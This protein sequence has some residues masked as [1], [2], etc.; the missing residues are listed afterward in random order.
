M[1]PNYTGWVVVQPYSTNPSYHWTSPP[2]GTNYQVFVGVRNAGSVALYQDSRYLGPF[3]IVPEAPLVVTGLTAN[4]T[5]P[6]PA[7][8]PIT[9]TATTTGGTAPL[10]Y[11]FWRNTNFTGWVIVQPY[12]TSNTYLWASPTAGSHQI[13]VGVRNAGSTAIYDQSLG[14]GSF[15]VTTAVLTVTSLTADVTLPSPAGV[16]VTFTATATGGTAPLQ[17]QFWRNDNYAGWVVVQPYSTSHTYLWASPTAGIIQVFVGVRNAGSTALFDANRTLGPFTITP[18]TLTITSLT[19]DVTLPSP[20]GVPITFTATATGGIAPLQY[21]FW[22]N[23]NYA[24]WVVV[25]PY[26]TSNTYL[27][28]SPVAGSAYQVF[29]GVRS[30]GS[31]AIYDKGLA[32]GPFV[33][34]P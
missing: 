26:S 34:T 10:Q 19:P 31:T 5:F 3:N 24:G 15:T 8:T 27:W 1:N 33:I 11:Q 6:S 17:Y 2:A 21:Q 16:P 28:A 30:A 20:A 29:V 25:Q 9:W 14:S 4:V 13:F 18:A 7:G 23:D 12:S 22:R 32:I